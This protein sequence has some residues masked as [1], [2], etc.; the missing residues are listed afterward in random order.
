M[1]V[2]KLEISLINKDGLSLYNNFIKLVLSSSKT[3]TVKK[4]KNF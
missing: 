1:K 3:W 2:N 4:K